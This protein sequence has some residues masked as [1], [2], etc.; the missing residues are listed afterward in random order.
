MVFRVVVVGPMPD[1]FYLGGLLWHRYWHRN[2]HRNF[3]D[4]KSFGVETFGVETPV[5]S[6]LLASKLQWHRNFFRVRNFIFAMLQLEIAPG[7]AATDGF[8][9]EY[10]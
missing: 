8:S 6:K 1:Q 3:F 10:S 7:N 4:A 2:W 9:L 5:A